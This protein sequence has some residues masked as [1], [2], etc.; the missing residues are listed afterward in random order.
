MKAGRER[1]VFRVFGFATTHDALKAE[2][3]LAESGIA[4]VP[5]PTPSVLGAACGIAMRVAPQNESRARSTL[6]D[7]GI[8][9][10]AEADIEDF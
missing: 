3:A 6:A 2:K 7:R 8:L 4:A 9:V 10:Q 5:I 1:K